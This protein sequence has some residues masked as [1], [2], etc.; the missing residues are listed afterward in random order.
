MQDTVGVGERQKRIP[1][2]TCGVG[3]DEQAESAAEGLR[4]SMRSREALPVQRPGENE[5]P[6]ALGEVGGSQRPK[7]GCKGE[8]TVDQASG[9]TFSEAPH[10][11][12]TQ[13][14]GIGHGL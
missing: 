10:F 13:P 6:G 12:P 8:G 3:A 1:Y 4:E 9:N 11:S 5:V 2:K 7:L 14:R